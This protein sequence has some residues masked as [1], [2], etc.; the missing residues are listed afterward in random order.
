MAILGVRRHVGAETA[1]HLEPILRRVDPDDERRAF[2]LRSERRTQPDRAL[3]EHGNAVTDFDAA[4]FRAGE[5][6]RENVRAQQDILVCEAGRDDGEVGFRIRNEQILGPG[7]VDGVAE[8][9]AAHW[10]A[11]LRGRS[12]Q[13]V[14]ALPA[15]RDG[16][17]DD[18]IADRVKILE[19]RAKFRDDPNRFMAEA[20]TVLDWILDPHG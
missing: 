18:T 6:G 11:A 3:R 2:E 20:E 12:V 19:T 7:A 4:A 9:P 13:A 10:A 5:A 8:L 15:R 14:E 16:P 17:N 1:G